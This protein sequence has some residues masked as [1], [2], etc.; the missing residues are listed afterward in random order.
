[1]NASHNHFTDSDIDIIDSDITDSDI[2]D[3]D[4]TDSDI[5]DSDITDRYW[6]HRQMTSPDSDLTD[7]LKGPKN[8][9]IIDCKK[10]LSIKWSVG[11]VAVDEV[12]MDEVMNWIL[13]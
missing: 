12:I 4:I 7:K 2:T 3:S 8:W 11:E 1:M 10:I 13:C 6:R 9:R 5:T